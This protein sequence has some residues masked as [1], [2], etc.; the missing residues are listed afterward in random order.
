MG[1]QLRHGAVERGVQDEP[2]VPS[3]AVAQVASQELK[4]GTWQ[5]RQIWGE[6]E[7]EVN[8]GPIS[9]DGLTSARRCRGWKCGP[10]PGDG[11][12]PRR[13]S[14]K[15]MSPSRWAAAVTVSLT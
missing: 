10:E 3:W 12:A 4:C 14:G 7:A 1:F 11:A 5:Q 9:L 8:L 6:G 13:Q 15:E 2:R